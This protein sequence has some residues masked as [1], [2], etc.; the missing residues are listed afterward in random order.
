M[1]KNWA[2]NST[3][4]KAVTIETLLAI[5]TVQ[6][7]LVLNGKYKAMNFSTEIITSNADE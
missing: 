4:I 1:Y 5:R 7:A 3:N 2:L 6:I